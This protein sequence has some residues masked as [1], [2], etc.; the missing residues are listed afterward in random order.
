MKDQLVEKILEKYLLGD[1]ERKKPTTQSENI[2]KYVI[3]RW[4]DSGVH[5]GK[6]E[7]LE[8][9]R[10]V[11]S[12]SRRLRR[13]R[14]KKGISL[15]GVATYGLAAREEVKICCIIPRIEIIDNRVSE[16]IPCS[17]DAIKSI[18]E[19]AEYDPN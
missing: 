16:I 14:A 1:E 4:Y 7:V 13:F 8:V 3:I 12:E 15:S 18:K 19:Y 17:D 6:L 5:F 11:L 2:W 9:N 10:I